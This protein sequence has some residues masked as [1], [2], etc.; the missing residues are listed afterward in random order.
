M[1]VINENGKRLWIY[2][3]L[4]DMLIENLAGHAESTKTSSHYI[5]LSEAERTAEGAVA[6]VEG[7]Y[8]PW[9]HSQF[10]VGP[11]LTFFPP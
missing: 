4:R 7:M 3:G 2:P 11:S 8:W 1:Q 9:T 5:S 10:F 6:C